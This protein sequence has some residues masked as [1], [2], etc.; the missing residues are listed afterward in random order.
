LFTCSAIEINSLGIPRKRTSIIANTK[1]PFERNISLALC[2]ATAS[3]KLHLDLLTHHALLL[4][5]RFAVAGPAHPRALSLLLADGA[6]QPGVLQLRGR[7]L[8]RQQHLPDGPHVVQVHTHRAKRSSGAGSS[9]ANSGGGV[10]Q[11]AHRRSFRVDALLQALQ[12]FLCRLQFIFSGTNQRI[13][14]G[15]RQVIC[16][17]PQARQRQRGHQ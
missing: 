16:Q 3:S 1:P 2:Q 7:L 5:R 6:H 8:Q 4:E 13:Q 14:A 17:R 10:R 11:L 15:S 9:G 12:L